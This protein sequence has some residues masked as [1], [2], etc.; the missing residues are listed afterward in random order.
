MLNLILSLGLCI[1]PIQA[2]TFPCAKIKKFIVANQVKH[3]SILWGTFG[4]DNSCLE[5]I[6]NTGVVKSVYIHT[7]NETCRRKQCFKGEVLKRYN[8][9][10]Y[11][12]LIQ[13][14]W[15]YARKKLKKRIDNIL[16][17]TTQY[18]EIKWL[19]STGLEDNFNTKTYGIIYKYYKRRLKN[20]SK[21]VRNPIRSA[22]YYGTI[23]LHSSRNSCKS[24]DCIY[25]NDGTGI[26]EIDR[27]YSG[28]K[29]DYRDLRKEFGKSKSYVW[30]GRIQGLT[31]NWVRPS[32]R[33]FRFNRSDKFILEEIYKND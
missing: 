25:S 16:A 20:A 4:D 22:P 30:W 8:A 11:N 32:D 2:E 27:D 5:T 9:K 12:E 7:T 23:E 21:I 29:S 13:T 33:R 15:P 28:P 26:S 1:Y 31:R 6:I 10:Q 17:F 19:Y 18:P 24:R 14:N 3:I